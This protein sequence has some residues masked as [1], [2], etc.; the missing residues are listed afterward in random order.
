M[1]TA[2]A[3]RVV[4][5]YLLAGRRMAL[6][7]V[8]P[9]MLDFVDRLST[10]G[11]PAGGLIAEVLLTEH[12][13]LAGRSVADAFGDGDAHVIGIERAD[14]TFLVPRGATSLEPG[15]RLML[16]GPQDEIERV[17]IAASARVDRRNRAE[18]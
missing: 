9:L 11:G 8:Q 15:A 18:D 13:P 1:R 6:T 5:P 2:G 7:A 14:G 10:Q 3:N 16:F 12:S 4:S 17:S